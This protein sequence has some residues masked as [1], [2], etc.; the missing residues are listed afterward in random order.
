MLVADIRVYM[1]F[2]GTLSRRQKDT[3]DRFTAAVPQF[4]ATRKL[5][6]S[7][8]GILF[9]A[10]PARLGARLTEANASS[11]HHIRSLAQQ[12]QDL[13]AWLIPIEGLSVH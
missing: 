5:A 3:L 10:D 9:G 13:E 4:A 11:P 1:P 2:Q 6:M 8:R 7:F 12:T